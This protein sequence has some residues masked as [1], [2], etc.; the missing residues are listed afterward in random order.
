MPVSST[1]AFAAPEEAA[2]SIAKRRIEALAAGDGAALLALS[3]PG[4][5]SAAA[6]AVTA[7]SLADGSLRFADLALINVDAHLVETTPGGAI[8]EVTTTLSDYSVGQKEVPG[9]TATARLELVLTQRG[10]LVERILPLP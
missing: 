6:D 9:G 2:A 1:A 5:P 7:K 8:V 10:W 3:A 4:S